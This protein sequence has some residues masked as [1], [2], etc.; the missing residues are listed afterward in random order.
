MSHKF[1]V[2]PIPHRN[3]DGSLSKTKKSYRVIDR[4]RSGPRLVGVESSQKAAENLIA[5][6]RG[7]LQLHHLA[8][9]PNDLAFK[10]KHGIK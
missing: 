3:K 7:A 9:H 1:K 10:R 2:E 8:M 6:E 5:L 4:T